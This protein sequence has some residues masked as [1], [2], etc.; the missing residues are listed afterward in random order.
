MGWSLPFTQKGEG[1]IKVGVGSPWALCTC[2]GSRL[3]IA[4]L[5]CCGNTASQP[6]NVDS[7]IVKGKFEKNV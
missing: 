3:L 2:A 7:S 1:I 5:F 6:C 4:P